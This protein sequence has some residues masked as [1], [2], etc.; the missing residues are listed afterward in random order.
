V[1]LWEEWGVT[2]QRLARS[3]TRWIGWIVD[4]SFFFGRQWGKQRS[5]EGEETTLSF[6][7]FLLSF[8]FGWCWGKQRTAGDGE[9][10]S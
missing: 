6:A 1:L 8:S 2:A 9:G 4:P 3:E 10:S 7:S 5:K